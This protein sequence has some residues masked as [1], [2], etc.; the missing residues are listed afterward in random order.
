MLAL[1]FVCLAPKRQTFSSASAN[2]VRSAG[3]HLKKQPSRSSRTLSERSV[4]PLVSRSISG[5]VK[6]APQPTFSPSYVITDELPVRSRFMHPVDFLSS[7]E[8][9]MLTP[10]EKAVENAEKERVAALRDDARALAAA[11]ARELEERRL[12]AMPTDATKARRTA[13]VS[14]AHVSLKPGQGAAQQQQQRHPSPLLPPPPKIAP[15]TPRPQKSERKASKAKRV[16][17]KRPKQ[18]RKLNIPQRRQKS[19]AHTTTTTIPGRGR[20]RPPKRSTAASVTMR[21][22]RLTSRRHTGRPRIRRTAAKRV[23]AVAAAAPR[24]GAASNKRGASTG[25]KKHTT[26]PSR[27]VAQMPKHVIM[28]ALSKSTVQAWRLKKP[29]KRATA[30]SR[31][32]K[33]TKKR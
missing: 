16:K 13:V 17:A 7:S 23:R 8:P 19:T 2:A 32:G 27:G 30:T 6:S 21:K 14:A 22:P 5:K 24:R 11:F 18:R 1:F 20:G 9:L 29:K 33:R 10:E 28:R 15:M 25:R 12:R 31:H 3:R 26:A 4:K